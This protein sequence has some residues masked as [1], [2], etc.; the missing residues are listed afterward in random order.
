[1]HHSLTMPDRLSIMFSTWSDG[2]EE[3]KEKVERIRDDI[4]EAFSYGW[5]PAEIMAVSDDIAGRA[6]TAPEWREFQTILSNC[7]LE[8][9]LWT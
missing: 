5:E 6:Y 9:F 3:E 2:I 8:V 7:V 4:R 1:M